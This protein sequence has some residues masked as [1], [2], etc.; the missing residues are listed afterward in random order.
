MDMS[1][2]KCKNFGGKGC[3]ERP[4]PLLLSINITG[5]RNLDSSHNSKMYFNFS[6]KQGL[7]K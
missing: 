5:Q 1:G 6:L 7:H 2:L 4:M 3:Q